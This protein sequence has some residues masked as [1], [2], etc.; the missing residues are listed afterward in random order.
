[1]ADFWLIYSYKLNVFKNKRGRGW[2]A[3][4]RGK[5]V[6]LFQNISRI[7]SEYGF[8]VSKGSKFSIIPKK[9]TRQNIQVTFYMGE[10]TYSVNSLDMC[11]CQLSKLFTLLDFMGF[12]NP[13]PPFY[14]TYMLRKYAVKLNYIRKGFRIRGVG[15]YVTINYKDASGIGC[16]QLMYFS[17]SHAQQINTYLLDFIQTRILLT[18]IKLR[19]EPKTCG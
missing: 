7:R 2:G 5:V 8:K 16:V 12:G 14:P 6:F 10:C 3:G 18:K 11:L 17:D 1:M 4:G 15:K 13:P 9:K 19:C